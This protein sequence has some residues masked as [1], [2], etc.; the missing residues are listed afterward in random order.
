[1]V[2]YCTCAGGTTFGSSSCPPQP[3]LFQG[4]CGDI[5]GGVVDAGPSDGS[6]A[7]DAPWRDFDGVCRGM[8]LQ[9][10]FQQEIDAVRGVFGDVPIAGVLTYGEIARYGGKLDG[11]HN[12]T[13]VVVAIP[14]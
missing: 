14:A 6:I 1:M 8:I 4:F 12:T 10:R 2:P 5:D 3:Y 9:D 11:W 7:C 13:A